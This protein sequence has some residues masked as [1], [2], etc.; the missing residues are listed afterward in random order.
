MQEIGPLTEMDQKTGKSVQTVN[1][2]YL[3]QRAMER[4]KQNPYFEGGQVEK[5]KK[6]VITKK[7]KA[8]EKRKD[9]LI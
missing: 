1:Y 3:S 4:F 7:Q 2:T 9:I 8:K 5:I 6:G